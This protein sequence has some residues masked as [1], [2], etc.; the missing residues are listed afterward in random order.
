MRRL[1]SL[2]LPAAL[3]GGGWFFSQHYR[4]EGWENLRVLPRGAESASSAPLV[5]PG[6]AYTAHS[7]AGGAIRIASFNIQVYGETKASKPEVMQ[8]LAATIRQFDVVAVQEIRSADPRVVDQL[9]E[10][11]NSSGAKYAHV[12]G[13]RLGRTV[14]KEQYAYIFNTETVQL[15]PLSIYTVNDPDDLL[16]REPLVTAFRALGAPQR[17]AFTFTLVNIHTDPDE[18]SREVDTLADVYRAVR[19]DGRGEDDIILLGDL[20]ADATELGRLAQQPGMAWA[21][22]GMPTNTRGTAAYDNLVFD[23]RATAEYTGNS[24]V[25][26]LMRQYNITLEQALEVSD[27]LPVWAEFSVYEGG[28]G[29]VAMQPGAVQ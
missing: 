14:S 7:A 22:S 20:N 28:R 23:G 11:V 21:I 4:I 26:D 16:H 13:P 24:G 27:H 12:L 25:L 29:P 19:N 17:E 2:L 15:D 3:I 5:V 6:G 8:I 10:L 1:L 18:V 9:V